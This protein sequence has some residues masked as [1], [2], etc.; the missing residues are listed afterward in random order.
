MSKRNLK[1]LII[2]LVT[3]VIVTFGYLYFSNSGTVGQTGTTTGTNFFSQFFPTS[4]PATQTTDTIPPADISGFE[5]NS[6]TETPIVKLN[7]VSS[8]PIA[9][10]GIFM[11]ERFKDVPTV[12]P[13]EQID[14][15]SSPQS[16]TTETTK[17]TPPPTEFVPALRYVD[18]ATGNIYQTF[19]DKIDERKFS[20]TIIPAVRESYLANSGE[21]VIMRYL[22]SDGITIESFIGSLPKEFLGADTTGGNEISGIFLPENVTDVSISPNS[23]KI[24]Y[25]FNTGNTTVGITL[26][27]LTNKK[28]QVFDSS[29]TEWTSFWPNKNIITLTSK[30]SA[31]VPGYM[32]AINPDRKD[33]NKILGGINGLTTLMSPDGKLVLYGNNN[34][35]LSVYNVNTREINTLG[36]QTLPEKCVWNKTS[37]VIYCAVPKFIE[38]K[39]Y[40]DSWYMGETSFSDELWKINISDGR[41][42]II[43]DMVSTNGGE[44][45]DTIKLTLDEGENYLFFVNKKD[46]YLWKLNLK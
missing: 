43:S 27:P 32:Y 5:L 38:T 18:R 19:A 24:F 1:L 30:P 42:T 11:K 29:F 46:S 39:E 9:G 4:K 13:V 34:L 8:M 15:T 22:K 44:D 40:P 31:N 25:L 14:L 6:T 23:S 28:S 16:T 2:A 12:I 3:I 17:P 20:E 35:S 37:D 33:F 41:T 26:D 21:S 36:I 7:K 45:I 10:Y